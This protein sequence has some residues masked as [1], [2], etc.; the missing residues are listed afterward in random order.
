MIIC[1]EVKAELMRMISDLHMSWTSSGYSGSNL[2]KIS[3][4][5]VHEKFDAEMYRYRPEEDPRPDRIGLDDTINFAKTR[6]KV[7]DFPFFQELL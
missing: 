4:G 2:S 5:P 7:I 6:Q 3:I 1:N